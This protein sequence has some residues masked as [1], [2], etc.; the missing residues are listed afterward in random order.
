MELKQIDWYPNCYN[1]QKNKDQTDPDDER[2]INTL[3]YKTQLGQAHLALCSLTVAH[4]IEIS[5]VKINM[6]AKKSRKFYYVAACA[7]PSFVVGMYNATQISN[8]NIALD[9]KYSPNYE[10]WQEEDKIFYK[11]KFQNRDFS[12]LPGDLRQNTPH[13]KN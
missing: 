1:I 10:R 11:K 2:S 3:H 13:A 12:K 6:I 4:Q 7:V 5:G 9:Q 8:L